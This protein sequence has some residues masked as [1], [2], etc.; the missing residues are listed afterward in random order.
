MKKADILKRD[1]VQGVITGAASCTVG[2]QLK[3][4]WLP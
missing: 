4:F 3:A 1:T 2:I